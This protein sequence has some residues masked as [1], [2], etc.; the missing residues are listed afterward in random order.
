MFKIIPNTYIF[1]LG[2]KNKKDMHDARSTANVE[3]E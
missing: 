2:G 1:G 3:V